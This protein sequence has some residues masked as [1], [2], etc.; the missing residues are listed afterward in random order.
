MSEYN[1][2]EEKNPEEISPK[3]LLE[4]LL[5]EGARKMLQSAIENEVEEYIVKNQFKRDERGHRL[6]ARNGSL[7]EREIL[8]GLGLIR[9]KQPRVDDRKLRKQNGAESFTSTILPPYLRRI[10][11]IDNLIP[12]LYLR[13][14]STGA[15]PQALEAILGERAK[16]LSATNIVRLKARW[17]E[18]YKEW[19]RR[20][21]SEKTYVYFWVDGVYFNVR[22]DDDRVCVLVIMAADE[23][24]KKELLVVSDGYRESK[25]SW[26]ELLLSLRR[27]GLKQGPKLCIGDGNLGFWAAV[28]EVF[29]TSKEQR[30]WVHKT[31]NILDKLPKSMQSKA[32]SHIHDMYEAESKESA[33]EAYEHFIDVYEDKFPKAVE[34]LR[35]DKDV[36]FT[37]YEFPSSH[38]IHIRTINPIEST[39][40]T[41]RLRTRRTK[42]CGSRT[43]TMTMVFKLAKEAQ[44]RWK[45][46]KGYNMIPLVLQERI[47]ID[48]ELKEEAYQA[49]QQHSE[50]VAL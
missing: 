2:K 8:T 4:E 9:V 3:S 29:P 21:L 37:F 31:A 19:S 10:P 44:K 20:D 6:A 41:V 23:E 47:F 33:L 49:D 32:K 38:W 36:L 11:S 46:L 25:L 34:C 18:E 45:R 42:G 30:C 35:K 5:R 14:I 26:K 1:E 28:R 13:G 24:G 12:A 50:A 40:A 17:E 16:G 48:G 7:P 43:A 27:R 15:F 22:L 39:F